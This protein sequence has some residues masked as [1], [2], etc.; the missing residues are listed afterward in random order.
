RVDADDVEAWVRAGLAAAPA[1]P[2]VALDR[3]DA[4]L[5]RVA[6]EPFAGVA[7]LPS[8]E[9]AAN[10]LDDLVW[11]AREER[12]DLLAGLGRLDIVLT[13]LPADAQREPLRE[14]LWLTLMRAQADDG[15]AGDALATY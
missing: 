13:E 12:Y 11:R 4:A 7:L 5:A 3:L 2:L 15:H 14:R 8:I 10:R 6:G 1:D 9:I